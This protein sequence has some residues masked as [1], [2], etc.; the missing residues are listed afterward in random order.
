MQSIQKYEQQVM[1]EIMSFPREKLPQ[2]VRLLR[3]LRED[4]TSGVAPKKTAIK[5]PWES[6]LAKFC[7][8]VSCSN[9]FMKR[10]AD[11]KA[12]ER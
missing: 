11:E 9:D 12:L 10:K 4:F 1:Q 7:G 5:A 8:R 2:V 3:M 6:E